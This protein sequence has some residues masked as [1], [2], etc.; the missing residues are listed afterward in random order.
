MALGGSIYIVGIIFFKSDGI[1]PFAHAIWHCFV[2]AAAACHYF[3]VIHYLY[4]AC[5]FAMDSTCMAEHI[6]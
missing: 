2:A 6:A 5:E 1:I 3:A 4:P